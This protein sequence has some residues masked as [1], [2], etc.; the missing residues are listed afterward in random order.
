MGTRHNE[1]NMKLSV[2]KAKDILMSIGK[3]NSY[4]KDAPFGNA[5]TSK[6]IYTYITVCV[7]SGISSCDCKEWI[8]SLFKEMDVNNVD[9]LKFG[10]D[11]IYKYVELHK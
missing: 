11:S 8:V 4:V 9:F 7:D 3:E 10:I 6:K 5:N 1:I 2:E